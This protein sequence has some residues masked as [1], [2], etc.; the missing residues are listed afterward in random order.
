MAAAIID[1]KAAAEQIQAELA[2]EAAELRSR[3]IEPGL[4]VVLVGEDP[5]SQTYVR[6]KLRTAERLGIR[7]AAP[8]ALHTAPLALP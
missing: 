7:F 6:N 4:D 1:G 3:G 8:A 2:A 5:A